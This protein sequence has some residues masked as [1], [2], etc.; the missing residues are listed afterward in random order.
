M[1]TRIGGRRLCR[2]TLFEFGE[3]LALGGVMI[4]MNFLGGH[5][6]GMALVYTCIMTVEGRS[7]LIKIGTRGVVCF[8]ISLFVLTFT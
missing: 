8:V 4:F 7:H 6:H 2:G 1:D 5:S 3:I